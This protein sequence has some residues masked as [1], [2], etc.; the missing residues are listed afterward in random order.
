MS[1][2]LVRKAG[3]RL[4]TWASVS[5]ILTVS[6][7]EYRDAILVLREWRSS[8]QAPLTKV[9]M[10]LRSAV[11]TA[12]ITMG[13]GTVAQRL[14][15]EPQII[16]KLR[17]IPKMSLDR[18]GDIA[19][20]RAVLPTLDDVRKV[21]QRLE[22]AA[23][24]LTIRKVRDYVE[25]PQSSGYRAV[26]LETVRD[27]RCVEIQLRTR[28]QHQW[29]EHVEEL[30]AHLRCGLK[31]DQGDEDVLAYLRVLGNTFAC[32]DQGREVTSA[33]RAELNEAVRRLTEY[34][35]RRVT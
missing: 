33:Q 28:L 6:E 14:K 24:K 31:D 8:F 9:V 17:R 12:G 13:P 23:R 30:E 25:E 11:T 18:M 4:R 5:G 20:C 21:Q 3:E 7:D 26:H 34:L 15:R 2:S 27:D 29:A 19:G 35:R 22:C 32:L 1:K 10:G 16:N